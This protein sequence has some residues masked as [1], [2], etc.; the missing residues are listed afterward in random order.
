MMSDS[1]AISTSIL[2]KTSKRNYPEYTACR[3]NA[4]WRSRDDLLKYEEALYVEREYEKS[5]EQLMVYNA[6][7]TKK[8]LSAENGDNEVR[9]LMIKSWTLCEDRIGLWDDCIAERE[10]EGDSVRPYYMRRFES[11]MQPLQLIS[12]LL[13][14]TR[15]SLRRLDLYPITRPRY[16]TFREIA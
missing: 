4:I 7:K 10:S 13:F 12:E 9:N 14:L 16:R 6:S 5:I 15:D 11:G 8:V 3:S 1:N 2:A